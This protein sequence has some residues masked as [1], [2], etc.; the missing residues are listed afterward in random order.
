MIRQGCFSFDFVDHVAS[1][2][3]CKQNKKVRIILAVYRLLN[4]EN[5]NNERVKQI[6]DKWDK[7][8]WLV[9]VPNILYDDVLWSIMALNSCLV[10]DG[11]VIIVTNDEMRDHKMALNYKRKFQEFLETKLTRLEIFKDRNKLFYDPFVDF[12]ED[13]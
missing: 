7:N 13:N 9:R 2:F 11:K 10:Y 1:Y 8:Q 4:A 12:S 3:A 5:S 6:I